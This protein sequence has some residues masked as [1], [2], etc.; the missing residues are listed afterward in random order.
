MSSRFSYTS[1]SDIL[2]L[3]TPIYEFF[4]KSELIHKYIPSGYKQTS[5][6][7]GTNNEVNT[8]TS[9]SGNKKKIS[10]R[11]AY[12]PLF[13]MDDNGLITLDVPQDT[14][15]E[16]FI[17]EMNQSDSN[18]INSSKAELSPEIYFHGYIRNEYSSELYLAIISEGY[19]TDLY[20][21]YNNSEYQGYWDKQGDHLTGNDIDI[22]NQL[23]DLL[24]K[25]H[26]MLKIICF[27]IKPGNCVINIDTNEVKLIDWDADWCNNYNH[28]LS[29]KGDISQTQNISIL[30]QIIM[31][32]HFYIGQQSGCG[33][34]IFSDYFSNN[35]YGKYGEIG[36]QLEERRPALEYLFCNL[37]GSSYILM[38]KHYFRFAKSD[39]CKYMIKEMLSRCKK[40]K[41]SL[42]GGKKGRTNMS[43]KN[44]KRRTRTKRKTRSK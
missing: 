4:T 44:K 14:T 13:Y 12:E 1:I 11:I 3:Q 9:Q 24:Y 38:A 5:V 36:D 22:A 17:T 27:D 39:T 29:S 30:S 34:N 16:I 42:M 21:Y 19:D 6:N 25:S 32:N 7:S 15:Q 2:E 41:P 8:Y 28:M 35:L 37:K 33:W 40:L 20:D 26:N 23:I 18:W 31:A 10:I 43:N